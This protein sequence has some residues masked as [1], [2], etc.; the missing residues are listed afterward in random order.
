MSKTD[1]NRKSHWEN[2]YA[3]KKFTE[4][5]WYQE[6]PESS[7]KFLKEFN[8]EKNAAIIDV[9]GGDSYFVDHLLK[10]GYTD[11]TV[12]D[13]SEK[14]IERAK[15]RLGDSAK[16]VNWIVADASIFIP[17]RH[18]DFWHDRAAFHFLTEEKEINKYISTIQNHLKPEGLVVVATFSED[19]PKKCSGIDI[20]Q[21]SEKSLSDLLEKS[22]KKVRC[23]TE[24]HKTPFETIQNFIFCSFKN[25]A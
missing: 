4:V 20:K 6:I 21:Y 2:I 23:F 5:S 1:F 15:L 9:G 16:N 14:A 22:F 10:R 3:T 13:I 12:L 17:D 25:V 19:G 24:N 7:L 18:Y 11:I 8:I